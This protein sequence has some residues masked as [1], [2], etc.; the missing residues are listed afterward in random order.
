MSKKSGWFQ[1]S[2][3]HALAAK[4]VETGRKSKVVSKPTY[5]SIKKSSKGVFV[6][7]LK[8]ENDPNGNPQRLFLVYDKHGDVISVYD[9]GYRGEPA[10]INRLPHLPSI[11]ISKSEYHDW[12][13][14]ARSDNKLKES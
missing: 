2:Q 5:S 12:I 11:E 6:Q 13:K 14:Q 9:E 1:Q 10:D 7:H 8:A 4:G 3:R